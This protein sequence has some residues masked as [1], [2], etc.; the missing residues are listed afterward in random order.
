MLEL[1]DIIDYLNEN[2]SD[3][4]PKYILSK[5]IIHSS[6]S[7][8]EI[9]KVKE[10]KWYQQL[11]AEQWDNGSWGRFHTQDTKSPLKNKFVTTEAALRRARELSLDKNDEMVH[12]TIQ[13]MERYLEG[14]EKWLDVNE[15]H[16]G[17]QISFRTIV[18]ANLSL[19]DP[20][21]PLVQEKKEVV[22]AHLSKAFID[23]FLYEDIWEKE[24][25]NSNE[26]L[27][28]PYMVYIIWL[29]QNNDFLDKANERDYLKYIWYR[30]EG[31][32]YCTNGPLSDI[33]FLESKNFLTWLSGLESLCNF[34][35][36]PE[37]MSMGTSNHLINEIHRLMYENV[38]LPKTSP[39]FGHYSETWSN[40]ISRRNDMILR[41]LR[42]LIKC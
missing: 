14:Q 19:F 32:Y 3:P 2:M 20:K 17:F 24:N 6:T 11:A 35:L 7:V 18:A 34:S 22:A 9:N 30:K 41:I 21:H 15:H 1:Q 13:L 25:R 12:K 5:E 33:H 16:Y 42:V 38:S 10:T 29:L 36:F 28:R 27:L 4:V 8:S 37:F 31:I 26:V 40:R 23:G 39:I